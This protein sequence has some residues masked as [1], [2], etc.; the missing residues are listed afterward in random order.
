MIVVLC[1]SAYVNSPSLIKLWVGR[2]NDVKNNFSW[3]SQYRLT[4]DRQLNTM[5]GMCGRFAHTRWQNWIG[6]GAICW[7]CCRSGWSTRQIKGTPIVPVFLS[8]GCLRTLPSSGTRWCCNIVSAGPQQFCS[9]QTGAHHCGI[10]T[11]LL[12]GFPCLIRKRMISATFVSHPCLQTEI[13]VPKRTI[14]ATCVSHSCL[15]TKAVVGQWQN[16]EVN[17][18]ANKYATPELVFLHIGMPGYWFLISISIS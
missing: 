16:E 4:G 5:F 12:Q 13:A 7:C 18:P 6:K 1:V 9:S 17:K 3:E 8:Q 14:S 15:Q 10:V 11:S 2:N